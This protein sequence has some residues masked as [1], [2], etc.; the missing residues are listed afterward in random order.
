M[1]DSIAILEPELLH[2]L[3]DLCRSR[4]VEDFAFDRR[5][6]LRGLRDHSI[7]M[8]ARSPS[9]H[10]ASQHLLSVY[11]EELAYLL[12]I[13]FVET[14]LG[15]PGSERF[16]YPYER[17]KRGLIIEGV[18]GL[19]HAVD[20]QSNGLSAWKRSE[21]MDRPQLAGATPESVLAMSLRVQEAPQAKCYLALYWVLSAGQPRAAY[22]LTRSLLQDA[23][24]SYQVRVAALE[25]MSLATWD[26]DRRR[27]TQLYEGAFRLLERHSGLS[28]ELLFASLSLVQHYV[29]LEDWQPALR[30]LENANELARANSP[31]ITSSIHAARGLVTDVASRTRHAK[32]VRRLERAADPHLKEFVHAMAG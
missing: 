9:L 28:E 24:L 32:L 25:G 20:A 31:A 23:G 10:P 26:L 18:Q 27:A 8:S 3:D 6:L 15:T 12:R 2:V 30:L 1:K 4:G 29:L 14:Y 11:R 17:M 7:E 16:C 21:G 19:V 13:L 22:R 5:K